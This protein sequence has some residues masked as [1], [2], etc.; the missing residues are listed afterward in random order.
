MTSFI[1]TRNT[2]RW[3]LFCLTFSACIE[4]Y[5]TTLTDQNLYILVVDGFFVPNDTTRIT[6][7][8]TTTID[9]VGEARRE[10]VA[11]V[12]IESDQGATYVLTSKG[13][14]TFT[15]PPVN[16]DLKSKY[17]LRINS[18]EG[19]VY[20]SDFVDIKANH[21]LDSLTW[22][23]EQVDADVIAFQIY[24][25][26]PTNSTQH[27][28]WTYDETWQYVSND[29]SIYYFKEGQIIPRKSAEELYYCWKTLSNQ[30]YF[31]GNTSS[32]GQ[33]VVY[34]Y[35]LVEFLQTDIKF[36][37]GYSMNVKQYGISNGGFSYWQSIKKNSQNLG[38]L[39]DP[40]PSQPT[41]NLICSNEPGRK[42]VGY[43]DASLVK[44]QRVFFRRQAIKGPGEKYDPTGYETC[45]PEFLLP[46][47][48][49][50]AHLRNK[51]IVE[52]KFNDDGELIGYEVEREECVDCRFHGGSV[53]K[54]DYWN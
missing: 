18:W 27:Y 16:A 11:A 45:G 50:E 21:I 3:M 22:T 37:F 28:Y 35:R 15:L 4:P 38:S 29:H 8:R 41:S 13:D 26:D 40:L 30:D 44:T 19:P 7:S 23:E 14:G 31:L 25:H 39:F 24:A 47:D 6:L 20:T 2:I 46:A 1:F 54:P 12:H 52:P 5:D 36:Y 17:R 43:F 49:D 34:D 51:L 48:M 42:V 32:L 33:D 53:T 9:Y 10:S